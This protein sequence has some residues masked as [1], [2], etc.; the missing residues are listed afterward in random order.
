MGLLKWPIK[1]TEAVVLMY[2][3]II[4]VGFAWTGVTAVGDEFIC[5]QTCVCAKANVRVQPP[6]LKWVKLKCG[7]NDIK[8]SSIEELDLGNLANQ[9]DVITL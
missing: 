8:L 6:F 5:P 4:I 2:V 1:V 3:I 9:S 7:G